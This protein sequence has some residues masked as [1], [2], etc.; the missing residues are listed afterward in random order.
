M[1]ETIN[2]LRYP[3]AKRTLID[4]IDDL[5]HEN[6]LQ[7]CCFIEPYA[8]SAVVGLELLQRKSIHSLILC[9]KDILIY[10]FWKSVFSLTDDLCE[11]IL[12]TPITIE[13]WHQLNHYRQITDVNQASILDLGFAGLFFN[14]TNF[15]GILKANPIGGINQTSQY[16]IDC[17]FNKTR[18]IS[19]IKHLAKYRDSVE[20][21]CNDAIAFMKT[22]NARFLQESCFAYFDPPY[23]EKGSKIYRHFYTKQDHITL[24]KY[25]REVRHL[26]W[27]ISYDDAPFIC[28]LYSDT[29][30]QYRP[31]FLDYSCASKIRT[32]GKEL[33]I[34]NLPLP[35]FPVGNAVQ[36]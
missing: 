2:P 17:R 35:P 7:G 32:K 23:Y 15:S 8:G 27:L 4:Y 19:I 3:G 10:A 5:L 1:P 33:L 20:V 18:I 36:L 14:R 26:D 9:E 13:T 22:Q 30:A 11:R 29:G 28:G 25:V 34:S 16:N 6:N 21:Y 12:N 31:F 24:S